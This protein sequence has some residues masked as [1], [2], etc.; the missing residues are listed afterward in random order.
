[1]SIGPFLP[2]SLFGTGPALR[3]RPS[4]ST[5]SSTLLCTALGLVEG[6]NCPEVFLDK[7]LA[8]ELKRKPGA[9]MLFGRSPTLVLEEEIVGSPGALFLAAEDVDEMARFPNS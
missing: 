4:R 6:S 3:L 2:S 5:P 1:V 8:D 9:I 7:E